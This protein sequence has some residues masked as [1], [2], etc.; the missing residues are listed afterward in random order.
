MNTLWYADTPGVMRL[1]DTNISVHLLDV[2]WSQAHR[3]EVRWN[4]R[5]VDKSET[6]AF[7]KMQAEKWLKDLKELGFYRA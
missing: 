1:G 5:V 2:N 7:A 4:Q 6:L 3:F